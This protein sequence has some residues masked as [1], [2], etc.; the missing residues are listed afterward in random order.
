M[1]TPFGK[2]MKLYID[3]GAHDEKITM[4]LSGIPAGLTVDADGLAA[5]LAR[6]SPKDPWETARKEESA[7]VFESGIKDGVTTGEEIVAAVRNTNTDRKAYASVNR[8]PRPSHADYPAVMKY[9]KGADLSGGGHFSGRLTVLTC[10]AGY[11]A[12]CFLRREGIDVFAHIYSIRDIFDRPFSLTDPE[13]DT[14]ADFPVRDTEAGQ[15]MR[16]AMLNARAEGDSLGGVIECAVTGLRPGI[17]E[18]MFASVEAAVSD[19]VFSI[20]AV[21]GIEFGAGF[22]G[23]GFTGSEHNDAYYF[24]GENVRTYTNNNGGILG[25][26][27]TGMPIIFTAAIKPTPS[28]AKEQD[29]VD[30]VTR[31]AVKASVGGRH[32]A[33]I[34]P[35]A[36]PVVEAA[37]AL[38]ITDLLLGETKKDTSLA[39]LRQDIDDL[40]SR[41]V[42]LLCARMELSKAVATEKAKSGKA[43]FDP[44]REKQLL[45]KI[46]A[47]AGEYAAP[48]EDIYGLI[49]KYSK[50]I[51]KEIIERKR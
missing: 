8:F 38:A 22:A 24:D 49:L 44:E 12:L 5:F 36:V 47:A 10:T 45:Q 39:G 1:S 50:E 19:A 46:R 3:G 32:D 41:L 51:Q 21:K 25:G 20:P 4:R 43:V 34:V 26:M 29:T 48:A 31:K 42:S 6:R 14:D 23:T 2:N 18:H 35:R 9:G 33:C 13:R 28:I 15:K 40:D 27:T 37:A 17:G 30:L 11:I 7:P 16:E